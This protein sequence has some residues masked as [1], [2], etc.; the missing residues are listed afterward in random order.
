MLGGWEVRG[1]VRPQVVG[2]R[3]TYRE[4]ERGCEGEEQTIR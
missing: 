2:E 1:D 4:S 3:R